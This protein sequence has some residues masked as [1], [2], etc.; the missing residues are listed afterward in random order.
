[1]RKTMAVLAALAM[2]FVACG[3]DEEEP[4]AN[5]D[6]ATEECQ[7]LTGSATFTITQSD[8]EFSP[9]CAIVEL[10]QGL[11]LVNE[12]SRSHTFTIDGTR[13]D[14]LNP[15]GETQNLEGGP[16]GLQPGSF[17]VYCRFHGSADGSG[18]TME[19]RPS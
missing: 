7:D 2:L 1:M 3:G 15:A 5:G 19:I 16:E 9:R 11:T 6:G 13:I 4:P 10:T 14:I 17:I 12:G 18:M 8:N